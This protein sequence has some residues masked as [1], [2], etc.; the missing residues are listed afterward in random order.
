M[1]QHWANKGEKEGKGT[2][3]TIE[4]DDEEKCNRTVSRMTD[5]IKIMK[6]SNRLVQAKRSSRI[7]R[8]Y[9]ITIKEREA[10]GAREREK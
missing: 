2:L 5:Q 6:R 10:I 3:K 4:E 8:E 7:T 9:L 1:A